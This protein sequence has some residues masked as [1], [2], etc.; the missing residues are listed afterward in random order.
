VEERRKRR[1]KKKGASTARAKKKKKKKPRLSSAA[2]AEDDAATSLASAADA[3]DVADA[4][5]REE[6]AELAEHYDAQ[7]AAA[8]DDDSEDDVV[9]PMPLPAAMTEVR[10]LFVLFALFVWLLISSFGCSFS[11]FVSSSRRV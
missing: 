9:G 5:A 8:A 1:K 3:P 2:A 6:G 11:S 10:R 7:R 4:H